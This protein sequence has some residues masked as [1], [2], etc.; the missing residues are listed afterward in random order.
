MAYVHV[1]KGNIEV[2]GHLLRAGDALKTSS[3][4]LILAR[5]EKAE[6]LLFDLAQS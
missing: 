3:P 2:N 4:H 5:G 1:V 6:V